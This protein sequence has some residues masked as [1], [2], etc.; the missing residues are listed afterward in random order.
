MSAN[1]R[2]L[3]LEDYPPDVELMLREV[4]H[5]GY[6]TEWKRVETEPDF[7]ALLDQC[8]DLILADYN[9]PQFTGL[10]ALQLLRDRGIDIPFI[11]VSGTIG[12]DKAVDAMKAGANDYIIK[13][14][15]RLLGP[16]VVRTLR[17]VAERHGRKKAEEQSKSQLEELKRWQAV[18]LGREDRVQEL[19][20][21]VNELCRRLGE[22]IRYPSQES[23]TADSQ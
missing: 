4:Q 10:Q 13:K 14:Q 17:E 3:I 7:L 21:E 9:M 11:L 18:M 23:G 20:R 12:E 16:A 5:A 22:P 15:M 19:K 1:I 6:E 2:I 8:W